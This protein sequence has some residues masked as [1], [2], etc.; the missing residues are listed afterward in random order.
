M[1]ERYRVTV[2]PVLFLHMLGIFMLFPAI[3]DL[4]YSKVCIHS[5]NKN[6]CSNLHKPENHANL[7]GV[8][9][10]SAHWILG[11]S[12]CTALPS[13]IMAQFLGSWSDTYS[14]KV[15]MLI[16]PLGAVFASLLYIIMSVHPTSTPVSMILLASF[17]AGACGGFSSI[18]LTSMSYI[19]QASSMQTRTIRVG[20]LESM[21][22][23]GGTLGPLL[24]G[25]LQQTGGR[26]TVFTVILALHSASVIY[27]VLWV[28]DIPPRRT[29]EGSFLRNS[30]TCRPIRDSLC[31]VVRKRQENRRNYL[32]A[33]MAVISIVV[34]ASIG[35]M[36]VSFLYMKDDPLDW[37]IRKFTY[38]LSLRSLLGSITLLVIL[39]LVR[40]L[41]DTVI[42]GVGLISKIAG[43]VL[44]SFSRND[45]LAFISAAVPMFATW[46]T[47]GIRAAMSKMV[48]HDEHGKLFACVALIENACA[49]FAS[50]VYTSLYPATRHFLHGFVFLMGATSLLI[51]LIIVSLLHKKLKKFSKYDSV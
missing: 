1:T 39:P 33:L 34:M 24:E 12:L 27:I 7:D 41:P 21:V 30:C 11:S 2:E 5:Y 17:I 40:H 22:Y 20:I 35:E 42:I 16:P 14:R 29:P 19:A 6:I 38:Y 46:C 51:P 18:I 32:L 8:Q 28:R 26:S 45:A 37:G 47:P 3:L 49:L 43:L 50:G 31:T 25:W 4:I 13:I 15:P 23:A 9:T 10:M 44:L 48:E 36:D